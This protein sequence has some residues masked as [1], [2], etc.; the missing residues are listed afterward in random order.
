MA[1]ADCPGPRAGW[2]AAETLAQDD[3][4]FMGPGQSCAE[5]TAIADNNLPGGSTTDPHSRLL[6][7]LPAFGDAAVPDDAVDRLTAALRA[8]T[9]VEEPKR[10]AATLLEHQGQCGPAR[11]T[12]AEDGYLINDGGYSY[13]NPANR[14]AWSTAHLA[15]ISTALT[16]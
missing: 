9:R 14:F 7:P 8:R 13:R 1:V 10:L 3:G 15:Q 5:L 11:W 16:P 4:H 12:T 2:D 6:L